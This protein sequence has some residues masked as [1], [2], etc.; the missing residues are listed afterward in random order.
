MKRFFF[1]PL[2]CF[3][4]H[5]LVVFLST[6]VGIFLF[7]TFLLVTFPF[8]TFLFVIFSFVNFPFVTFQFVIFLFSFYLSFDSGDG[9][10]SGRAQADVFSH[11]NQSGLGMCPC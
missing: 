9:S 2:P 1:A 11:K 3:V 7:A 8:A 4:V 5:V 6:F 10:P